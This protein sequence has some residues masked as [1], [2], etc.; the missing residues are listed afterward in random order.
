MTFSGV[1]D[2]SEVK[3]KVY[4]FLRSMGFEPN[5]RKTRIL[6][7]GTRQV[8]TG[9]VVDERVRVPAPYRRRLRAGDLLLHEIW[10]KGAS[11]AYR[12]AGIPE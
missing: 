6:T 12:K 5:L 1:F 10:G 11:D 8:V 9:L 3:G 7:R 4:G 2:G